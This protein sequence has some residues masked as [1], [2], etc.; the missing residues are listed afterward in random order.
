MKKNKKLGNSSINKNSFLPTIII[1][2]I[3]FIILT[4]CGTAYCGS[5]LNILRNYKDSN[6]NSMSQTFAQ[7]FKN[8]INNECI[9]IQDYSKEIAIFNYTNLDTKSVGLY[10]ENMA[11]YNGYSNVYIVN[12][13]GQGFDYSNNKV[14]LSNKEYFKSIDYI[15]QNVIN[16]NDT[17]VYTTPVIDENQQFKFFIIAELP[18]SSIVNRLSTENW[19]DMGFY[20]L[21][22]NDNV[23]TYSNTALEK[24]TLEDIITDGNTLYSTDLQTI[25]KVDDITIKKIYTSIKSII[26]AN[27]YYPVVWYKQSIGIN[28]W[29]I[30]IGRSTINQ[31]SDITN[32]LSLSMV[33]LLIVLGTLVI[34]L[35]VFMIRNYI[36]NHKLKKLLY[37][38][39]LTGSTN[40]LKFKIDSTKELQ[41]GKNR[42]ALVSFDIYK[43]RIYCDINGHK[44][45]D[46][47][48]IEIDKH[49]NNF[50]G[51]KEYYAHKTA[52]TFDMFLLYQ[53]DN[54]LCERL[55]NLSETLSKSDKLAGMRFAFGIYIVDNKNISIN[56]MSI[57]ANMSK[58]NNKLL[59]YNLRET[60]SFF[61]KEMHNNAMKESD[62]LNSFDSALEN[63]EF[64]LYI[65]P[66]YDL[67]TET[68]SA[69]EAL[70]R[71]Q[72]SDGTFI[73]PSE[74]IPALEKNGDIRKLDK[75]MLESV[76]KKQHEWLDM[77]L[78][79]VPIS[80]NLSRACF[81][82]K[83]LAK[84]ILRLVDSYKIP[85]EYIEL[86][87]TE[88]AFF[89]NKQ[90]LIDTVIQ[91]K[92]FGFTVSMD[93]FG[94]GYSSLNS[95]KELPVDIVKLDG[96]FFRDIESNDLQ[97]S[98]IIV[99]NIIRL[100]NELNLKIVAEGVETSEQI[101][102][103]RSLGYDL[104]I[105]SYYYSKPIPN[106]DFQKLLEES[107]IVENIESSSSDSIK[108]TNE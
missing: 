108:N 19:N 86:E 95:L 80:V 92:K 81:S 38:D 30:L 63:N 39:T 77:G 7:Q 75:Y 61:T 9:L 3:S 64:L 53:D 16:Q 31:D 50:I 42:Y 14:D 48:L 21:D 15:N 98:N 25:T 32:L 94:A 54:T 72:K 97:K 67:N 11:K 82:D 105:Q 87:V 65:Q 18:F 57:M 99:H 36:S 76:C 20:I 41:K 52:D 69:G 40:W 4:L 88:S 1:I 60:I 89:D 51:K 93:D 28:G 6:Y 101:N 84:F 78:N 58:D 49:I 71:W 106:N 70:V 45:G 66:K 23:L 102:F 91:L 43:F 35:I 107:T 26:L 55:K 2:I 62:I 68:F 46:T 12:Y 34:I 10:L 56:R 74:F 96:G 100:A 22:S 8:V 5:M 85:H 17:L 73:P 24:S 37:L 90:L 33:M 103:L 47:A 13:N 44:K 79:I 104:L 83:S 27:E 59:D 29:S